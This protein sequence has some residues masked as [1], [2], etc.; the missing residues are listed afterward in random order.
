MPKIG[1]TNY[2]MNRLELYQETPVVDM[3]GVRQEVIEP[4]VRAQTVETEQAFLTG[5]I[6]GDKI[7]PIVDT[8][9]AGI[10]SVGDIRGWAGASYANRTTAPFRYD[11]A[12]NVVADSITITGGVLKHGKTSFTDSANA[13]YY[14]SSEGLYVGASS[15]V[16]K[17]KYTVS[18]GSFDFIGTI[19]SRSTVAL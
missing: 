14:L 17:L 11:R 18:D 10:T 2:V 8:G 6:P 1:G 16:S 19:S 15:D 5:G 13:G 12:G 4:D 3:L 9:N 7:G